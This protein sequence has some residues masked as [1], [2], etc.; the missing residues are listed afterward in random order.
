MLIPVFKEGIF[1]ADLNNGVMQPPLRKKFASFVH[2][3]IH[4]KFKKKN[5]L[6]ELAKVAIEFEIQ[7]R[8]FLVHM[9]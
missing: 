1:T 3:E 4:A 9:T 8:F 5:P 7:A 2:R 6:R